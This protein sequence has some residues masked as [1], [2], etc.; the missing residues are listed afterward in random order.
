MSS[1]EEGK[2]DFLKFCDEVNSH[3]AELSPEKQ[4]SVL[5]WLDHFT[6]EDYGRCIQIMKLLGTL[7]Y[8]YYNEKFSIK[9]DMKE[10]LKEIGSRFSDRRSMQCSFYLMLNFMSDDGNKRAQCL[11][12]IWDGVNG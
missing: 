11:E 5:F 12:Y 4:A 1:S 3:I 9:S 6:E 10:L 7:E 2:S 8:G